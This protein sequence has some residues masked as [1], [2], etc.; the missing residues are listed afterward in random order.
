MQITTRKLFDA[1]PFGTRVYIASQEF[2]SIRIYRK[3]C[4][5]SFKAF[6]DSFYA[7]MIFESG[8]K[9]PSEI[10][11]LDANIPANGYN[12][13]KMFTSEAAALS[14]QY[15]HEVGTVYRKGVEVTST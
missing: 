2:R 11:L 6:R 7:K 3:A 15:G 4:R 12:D 13:W 10:S 8:F 14:H 5:K 9:L 1:L